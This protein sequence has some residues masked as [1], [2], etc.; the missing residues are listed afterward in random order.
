MVLL[1]YGVTFVTLPLAADFET[2]VSPGLHSVQKVNAS[3]QLYVLR[4]F[5]L[6][7]IS[8]FYST[9]LCIGS[10]SIWVLCVGADFS[11]KRI[12]SIL[13]CTHMYYMYRMYHIVPL[14]VRS[15]IASHRIAVHF[16]VYISVCTSLYVHLCVL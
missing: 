1:L 8:V 6:Q 15:R 2:S 12:A 4:H 7:Y 14:C 13:H 9:S 10:V 5:I 11:P 3:V 16:C